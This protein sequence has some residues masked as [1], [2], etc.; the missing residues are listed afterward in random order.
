LTKVS[1]GNDRLG[2][3]HFERVLQRHVAQ[4]VVDQCSDHS[5]SGQSHPDGD[6]L[7]SVGADQRNDIA[8]SQAQFVENMRNLPTKIVDLPEGP[9]LLLKK[10]TRPVRILFGQFREHRGG[11]VVLPLQTLVLANDSVQLH[12]EPATNNS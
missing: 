8:S 3:D 11:R 6:V 10:Q 2:V 12:D 4:R 1:T 7:G 5:K 9:Y